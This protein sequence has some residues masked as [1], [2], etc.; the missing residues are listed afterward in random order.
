MVAGS[1]PMRRIGRPDDMAGAALF[2]AGRGGSYLC[3]ETIVV[4]GGIANVGLGVRHLAEAVVAVAARVLVQVRLVVVL[5]VVED[6][7]AGVGAAGDLGGDLAEALG[8]E[9]LPGSAGVTP[10]RPRAG[11]RWCCRSPSGTGCRD[12][13]PGGSAWSG[14]GSPRT[15]GAARRRRRR[16]GRRR[17]GRSRCARSSPCTSPRRS[18]SSSSRPCSRPPWSARRRSASRCARRPRSSPSRRTA[19]RAR[20]ATGPRSGVPSTT[21]SSRHGDRLVPPREGVLGT[22]HR[23]LV[24]AE[25][26]HVTRL[27]PAT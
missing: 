13:C 14:R 17:P 24:A 10:A 16:P 9:R 21:C 20:R 2:L 18:G 19:P 26:R 6:A 5:G 11:R 15:P 22:D 25:E 12:R 3:G 27:L 1:V 7:V 8:L 23:R 4:D